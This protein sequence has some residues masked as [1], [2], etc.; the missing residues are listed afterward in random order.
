[1]YFPLDISAANAGTDVRFFYGEPQGS[2]IYNVWTRPEGRT[3]A[4]IVCIGGGAGGG[5]GASSNSGGGAGG[6]SGGVSVAIV[7]LIFLPETLYISVG[8]GGAGG[9]AGANG[10]GGNSSSVSSAAAGAHSNIILYATGGSGGGLGSSSGGTS[11][12]GRH[13]RGYL[14]LVLLADWNHQPDNRPSWR[15][16]RQQWGRQQHHARGGQF[17]DLWRRGWRRRRE[18]R[19]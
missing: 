6:G 14:E 12:A 4:Y 7:P 8:A 19:R 17:L 16:G 13:G 18:R 10:T 2:G 9:G 3:M 11:G 5:G 15:R 1:M